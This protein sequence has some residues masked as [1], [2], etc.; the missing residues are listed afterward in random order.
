M[1]G[2]YQAQMLAI[3]RYESIRSMFDL[4]AAAQQLEDG[5]AYAFRDWP[6]KHFRAGP[7]G[8]YTIWND[9]LFLYVGM[10]YTHRNDQNPRA[11]GVFG[12]LGSHA[13]G[14]RSGDQFAVYICDRFVVPQLSG[15]EVQAL[16]RGDRLLDRRTRDYIHDHLTYRVVLTDSAGTARQL[17]ALV[18][19]TGLPRAGRPLINP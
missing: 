17:E 3:A 11:H 7:S 15:D 10:A 12:R 18:R 14:R 16:A 13:N 5:S 19:R 2:T 1:R 6:A 9:N 4:S 8:V